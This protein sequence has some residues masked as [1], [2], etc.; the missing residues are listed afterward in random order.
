[1]YTVCII[2]KCKRGGRQR[3][4]N[5]LMDFLRSNEEH[6]LEMIL[7]YAKDNYYTKYPPTL[8][9]TWH[10]S[11]SGLS[12]ALI[13]AMEDNDSIPEIGSYEDFINHRLGEYGIIEAQKHRSR[14]I[15]LG[16]YLGLMKCYKL[17]Y[18]QL[19][20][21]SDF[22]IEEK[23]YFIQFTSWFFDQFELGFTIEWENR[24]NEKEY[25][26]LQEFSRQMTNERNKYLTVF[27]SI[28]DPMILLDKEN[29][30]V[31]INSQAAKVFLGEELLNEKYSD[32]DAIEFKMDWLK[33]LIVEFTNGTKDGT[34]DG[35]KVGTKDE[36]IIEKLIDTTLGM[37]IFLVKFKK[38]LDVIKNN[39]GTVIIFNDITDR[40][41]IQKDLQMQYEKLETVAYIDP[42]TG[43]SNRR[44][45][46]MLLEKELSIINN[47]FT[48][49][50]ICF[51]DIDGLKEVND[52]YG[53]AEGDALIN[54]IASTIKSSIRIGD[55]VS[56]MGG[57][58]F[59]I[60]FPNSRETDTVKVIQAIFT[61]LK[62]FDNLGIKQ[63]QHSFSYGIQEIFMS[64]NLNSNDILKAVDVKMYHNKNRK[65]QPI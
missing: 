39:S 63:Y 44:T 20:N 14:G 53:H 26:E 8:K 57:D 19:I 11:I 40:L 62:E 13:K 59:L 17:S 6:L 24:N 56:R 47:C 45:G 28:Y 10:L 16:M 61:K 31:N 7:K 3:K 25:I 35:T 65:K 34:K 48:P 37:K 18:I 51:I 60:I 9:E 15:T 30:V 50:S 1:M 33:E 52:T 43:V 55:S 54:F 4:M 42:L 21:E 23:S 5:N 29:H 64:E 41:K 27:E 12:S 49:L 38:M 22:S 58:E 32:N 2:N 46:L 36:L